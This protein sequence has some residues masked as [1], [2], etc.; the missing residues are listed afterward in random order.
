MLR[1]YRTWL[2]TSLRDGFPGQVAF[3]SAL[4]RLVRTDGWW[5]LGVV[6]AGT[7]AAGWVVERRFRR[8]AWLALY[9][10][11]GVVGQ[12]AGY[13]WDP[14]GAGSSVAMFG[15]FAGVWL[16]PPLRDSEK[17]EPSVRLVSVVGLAIV[18]SVLVSAARSLRTSPARSRSS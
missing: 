15:L 3:S 18:A 8:L 9:L 5:E 17:A 4:C 14:T 2:R 12:A 7:L 11:A 13:L 6:L 10:G 16:A 1:R